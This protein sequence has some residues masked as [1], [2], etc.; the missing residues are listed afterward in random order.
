MKHWFMV[1]FQLNHSV[2]SRLKPKMISWSSN[3]Y[4]A[5]KISPDNWLREQNQISKLAW[6]DPSKPELISSKALGELAF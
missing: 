5:E 2:T 6:I 4:K 3:W 1:A